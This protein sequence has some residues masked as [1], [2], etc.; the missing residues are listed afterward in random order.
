MITLIKIRGK[1]L[2]NHFFSVFWSYLFSPIFELII[3]LIILLMSSSIKTTYYE[4]SKIEGEAFNITKKL[5]SQNLTFSKYNF[6]LVSNDE[7]DKKIIQDLTKSNINWFHKESEVNNKNDIIIKINNKDEKYKIELIIQSEENKI[8][9]ESLEDSYSYIDVFKP[10]DYSNKRL[11]YLKSFNEFFQLQSLFA[12]YLI[13][14]KGKSISQK[15]LILEL[16]EN[17]YPP[18]ATNKFSSIIGV[19]A[20][21]SLQFSMA[22]YFFCIRMI[23]EKEKKLTELLERQGISKKSYFFSWLLIFLFINII[24]LFIQIFIFFWYSIKFIWYYFH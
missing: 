3:I 12:Q 18:H 8:L 24:P 6:S 13:K 15:E 17:S 19:I 1:Y 11:D 23:R 4:Q 14:K 21:A 7:K 5:F 20:I 22:S 2:S 9:S 16:G 10:P